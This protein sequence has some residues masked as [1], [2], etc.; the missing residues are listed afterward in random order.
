MAKKLIIF[1]LDGTLVDSSID[2]MNSINYAL[3]PLNVEPVS[4]EET[5]RLVGEGITRLI[6]KLIEQKAVNITKEDILN[7][8]ISHYNQHLLDHTLPYPKVIETLIN[9]R[10]F[11][12]AVVTNKL[13]S[14]SR[15][16][17]KG[18]GMD[19]FFELLVGSE[20]TGHKKPSPIPLFYVMEKLNFTSDE[21][22]IVGDSS[23][24]IEAGKSASIQTIAVT[25]GFRPK[26]T[27]TEADYII[28]SIDEIVGILKGL[29]NSVRL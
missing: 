25:Y 23:Y 21:T 3:E 12:K 10:D 15:A 20:T 9:L 14:M 6:E 24:D 29:N 7:R 8:F 28:D 2:L 19:G 18:L 5:K 27:L 17:L 26:E 13:E 1:D 22:L 11:T 4:L 16:I